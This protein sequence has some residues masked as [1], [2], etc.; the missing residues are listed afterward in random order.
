M[1]LT[2]L[3]NLLCTL[4]DSDV[5][6]YS[7]GLVH[8]CHIQALF[9]WHMDSQEIILTDRPENLPGILSYNILL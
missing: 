6:H 1:N 8:C 2:A 9:C 7:G 3:L 4:G 5:N